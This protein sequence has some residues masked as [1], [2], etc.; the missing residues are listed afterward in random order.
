[1]TA[2]ALEGSSAALTTLRRRIVESTVPFVLVDDPAAADLVVT[3]SPAPTPNYLSVAAT[4]TPDRFYCRDESVDYIF[5]ALTEAH[6]IGAH[7][8]RVRPPVQSGARLSYRKPRWWRKNVD[9]LHRFDPTEYD[10][11]TAETVDTEVFDGE[12]TVTVAGEEFTARLRARGHI[13]ANDGRFHWAGLLYGRRA[14]ELKG[15]G[16][17]RAQVRL[18]DGP[19]VPAKLAEITQWDNVRMTGVG[20]PPWAPEISASI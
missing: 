14:R 16:R 4:A 5:A 2:I 18:A 1:M 9:P 8:V 7:G 15:D 17:S 13:D 6:M 11:D 19:D 10:W 12:V 3:D 20:A